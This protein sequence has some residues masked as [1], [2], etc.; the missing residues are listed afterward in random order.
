MPKNEVEK[1]RNIN[2]IIRHNLCEYEE[3]LTFIEK[4]IM[5]LKNFNDETKKLETKIKD[6]KLDNVKYTQEQQQVF[7][8]IA[9]KKNEKEANK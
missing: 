4:A 9:S 6:L 2:E 1:I 7:K 3:T 5:S 8:E